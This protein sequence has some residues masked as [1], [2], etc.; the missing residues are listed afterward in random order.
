MLIFIITATKNRQVKNSNISV[1]T[2]NKI[3]IFRHLSKGTWSLEQAS[4]VATTTSMP[5]QLDFA[6]WTKKFSSVEVQSVEVSTSN[7]DLLNLTDFHVSRV[8]RGLFG[9][10]GKIILNFDIYEGDSTEVGP[11]NEFNL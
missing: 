6:K 5:D 2:V 9:L 8:G 3:L 11:C 1:E 7:P 4:E 10:S